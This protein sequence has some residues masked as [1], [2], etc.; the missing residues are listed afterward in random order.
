MRVVDVGPFGK[1]ASKLVL[2][3]REQLLS[4]LERVFHGAESMWALARGGGC[5][6]SF[7]RTIAPRG[8]A[9]LSPGRR[10]VTISVTALITAFSF[11]PRLNSSVTRPSAPV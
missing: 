1:L 9:G 7:T 10:A 2:V 3:E 11:V 6:R 8:L 4:A 5:D